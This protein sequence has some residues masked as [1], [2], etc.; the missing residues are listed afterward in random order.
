MEK[1]DKMP[2]A[3]QIKKSIVDKQIQKEPKREIAEDEEKFRNTMDKII[4]GGWRTIDLKDQNGDVV[5]VIGRNHNGGYFQEGDTFLS[6]EKEADLY[7][8]DSNGH[9]YKVSS[10]QM[11][12]DDFQKEND[13]WGGT[14]ESAKKEK[15]VLVG[16][17]VETTF[18]DLPESVKNR[19][20][21][22]M[23]YLLEAYI[24]RDENE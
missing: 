16:S 23:D 18:N 15:V 8:F 10:L 24:E 17:I 13:G 1:I 5:Q 4:A 20:L 14:S 19:W 11:A 2:S 7:N 12:P 22:D 3:E 21:E 9:I 6:G